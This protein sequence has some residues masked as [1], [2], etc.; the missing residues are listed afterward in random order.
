VC[1][2]TPVDAEGERR[3]VQ[4]G[5][6]HFGTNA[7]VECLG[8]V[9]EIGG[10]ERELEVRADLVG[11]AGVDRF[12]F[13]AVEIAAGRGSGERGDVAAGEIVEDACAE[14]PVAPRERRVA[15]ARDEAGDLIGAA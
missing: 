3:A 11:D 1:L 8:F 13:E 12:V 9:G 7:A 6:L 4:D 10:I 5:I 15:G 2:E 14:F